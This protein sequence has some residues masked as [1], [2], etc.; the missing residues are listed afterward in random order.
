MID[1]FINSGF[2]M[3][4]LYVSVSRG[5][6]SL[7]ANDLTQRID[8]TMFDN[9]FSSDNKDDIDDVNDDFDVE[10][11]VFL[12]FLYLKMLIGLVLLFHMISHLAINVCHLA[13]DVCRECLK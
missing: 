4:I 10:D 1:Y 12:L 2:N 3:I 13:I 8:D 11:E 7:L 9:S 5:K 6:N